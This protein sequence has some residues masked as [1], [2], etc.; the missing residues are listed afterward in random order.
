MFGSCCPEWYEGWSKKSLHTLW[1]AYRQWCAMITLTSPR[2]LEKP[3]S[4]RLQAR[5][6][7]DETPAQRQPATASGYILIATNRILS[8]SI[9]SKFQGAPIMISSSFNNVDLSARSTLAY[10]PILHYSCLASRWAL[11]IVAALLHHCS[12]WRKIVNAS[13]SIAIGPMQMA[14]G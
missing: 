10:F 12:I 3:W 7:K 9:T 8:R 5:I 11:S 1:G 6:A 14:A 13:T 4:R 2:Y